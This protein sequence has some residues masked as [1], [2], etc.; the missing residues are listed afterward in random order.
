MSQ[1]QSVAVKARAILQLLVNVETNARRA[2]QG[3]EFMRQLKVYV[4]SPFG[5]FPRTRR[6]QSRLIEIGCKITHDW[7]IGAEKAK[8]ES[9]LTMVERRKYAKED[10]NGVR[11][12]DVFALLTSVDPSKGCGMWVELGMAIALPNRPVIVISGAQRMR[13]IFASLTHANF[14]DDEG[15]IHCIGSMAKEHRS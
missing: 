2:K 1:M 3:E 6:V 7:T 9:E 11:D 5:E 13:T 15:L 10:R 8:P 12:C 4:A 14:E